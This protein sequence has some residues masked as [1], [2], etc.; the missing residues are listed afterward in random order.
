MFADRCGD[1]AGTLTLRLC[2]YYI[3]HNVAIAVVEMRDR[4][5]QNQKVKG[6]TQCTY[7]CHTLL[8]TIGHTVDARVYLIGN[9]EGLEPRKDSRS[10]MRMRHTVLNL[11]IL[12]RRKFAKKT[13]ILK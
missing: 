8:L 3:A 1:N 10:S 7:K 4:L 9:A 13:Q 12:Q 5:I 11:D 2:K 6:L